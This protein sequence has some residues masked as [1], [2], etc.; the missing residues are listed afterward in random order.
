[1]PEATSSPSPVNGRTTDGVGRSHEAVRAASLLVGVAA[2]TV[3]VGIVV[4]AVIVGRNGG[5][6]IQ[7]WDDSIGRWYLH[8]RGPLVGISKFIA[9]YFDALPLG[10]ICV[11]FTAV[12]AVTLRTVRSLIPVIA[13]FGAEFEVFAIRAVIHR[14]RPPTADY[15]A[16]G[17][18]SGVHEASYSFPSGHAAAVTA[19]LVALLGCIALTYRIWWPWLVAVAGSAFVIDTRLVLGVHWSSDVTFGLLMG[20]AWGVTVACAAR[21]VEWADLRAVART[22][23]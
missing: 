13:Y 15:P 7:G 3:M 18:V 22:G 14:H 4:G 2:G 8:H 10:I 1:M 12:L 5:G 9:T 16:S 6:P 19:V 11:V 20:C 21:R 17:A 23:R